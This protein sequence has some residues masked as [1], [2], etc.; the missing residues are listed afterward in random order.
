MKVAWAALIALAAL[1][2]DE[3]G[4]ELKIKLGNQK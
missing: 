4:N 1:G 3:A 2:F